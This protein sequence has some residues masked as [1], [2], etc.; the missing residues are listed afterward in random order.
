VFVSNSRAAVVA[1]F[2]GLLWL[3][4]LRATRMLRV[5]GVFLGIGLVAIV[6]HA[7]ATPKPFYTT[8]LYRLYESVASMTDF[9][10]TRSYQVAELSDKPDNNQFR[11]VWWHTVVDQTWDE[12]R[13]FGLGFGHDLGAEFFRVYYAE[14]SEEFNVRSPHNFLLS[15]FGRMG[16]VGS[17]AFAAFIVALATKT[18]RARATLME[19]DSPMPL[20][21]CA[22]TILV[23]ACFGVVLEGPMAAMIFWTIVGMANGAPAPEPTSELVPPEPA[24]AASLPA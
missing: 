1:F 24:T 14:S 22:W 20:W 13:W 21:L 19:A 3:V 16:I 12:G 6:I 23:S 11:L 15:I 4:A 17:L 9:K 5:F 18:W 2:A 8:P 7:I 10:G